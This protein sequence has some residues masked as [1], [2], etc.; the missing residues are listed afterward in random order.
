[1][2]WRCNHPSVHAHNG[3]GNHCD[4]SRN[5]GQA[6]CSWATQAEAHPPKGCMTS[7]KSLR[8]ALV[9]VQDVGSCDTCTL[10]TG[11]CPIDTKIGRGSG[12]QRYGRRK[13]TMTTGCVIHV[14]KENR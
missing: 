3:K 8:K 12:T 9:K 10:D 11:G 7:I 1:M 4:M 6:P 5:P 13:V 14:R 2:P